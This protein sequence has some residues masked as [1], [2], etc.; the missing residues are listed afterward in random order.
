MK[1]PSDYEYG[2]KIETAA[3]K[4]KVQSKI[5]SIEKKK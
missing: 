2:V 5:G 4:K 3:E 1:Q